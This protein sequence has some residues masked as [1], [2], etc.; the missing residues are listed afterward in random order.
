M[1][2]PDSVKIITQIDNLMPGGIQH[3]PVVVFR[4]RRDIQ[5]TGQQPRRFSSQRTS[6]IQPPDYAISCSEKRTAS[7][8]HSRQ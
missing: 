5:V 6:G 7:R 1:R 3:H 8:S 4:I 2:T